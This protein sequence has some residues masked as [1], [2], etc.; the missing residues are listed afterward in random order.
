MYLLLFKYSPIK[1]ITTKQKYPETELDWKN[2][3]E[4]LQV[5]DVDDCLTWDSLKA[6]AAGK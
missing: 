5:P 3:P 2:L 6:G 4:G 1:S